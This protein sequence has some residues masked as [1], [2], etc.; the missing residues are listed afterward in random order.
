MPAED[1][2]FGHGG[3]VYPLADDTSTPL[4]AR[5]DPGL[6]AVLQFL[7]ATLDLH[8]TPAFREYAARIGLKDQSIVH[9]TATVEPVPALYADRVRFPFFTVWRKSETY[10][11]HTLA[12]DKS[13]G[14][15]EFAY[16]LPALMPGQ[17]EALAA[18]LRGVVR[19]IAKS[20]RDGF[21][22]DYANGAEVLKDAGIMSVRLVSAKYERYERMQSAQANNAEQFFRAVTGTIEL[23]ERDTPVAGA[24]EP[25]GG[26][27]IAIDL[28]DD[29]DDPIEDFVTTE[30]NHT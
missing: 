2:T 6:W 28:A 17:Q 21:H 22:R 13:V 18:I 5:T 14:E 27:N 11:R 29:P 10:A 25:F 12:I 20:L 3:A 23:V 16:V 24:Y 7:A 4:I 26:A 9:T 30:T 8:L 19:V 1:R 15:L